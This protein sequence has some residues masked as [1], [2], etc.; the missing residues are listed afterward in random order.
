MN[1]KIEKSFQ[2]SQ[3]YRNYNNINCIILKFE[4]IKNEYKLSKNKYNDKLNSFI[5]KKTNKLI[6]TKI[7]TNK[8]KLDSLKKI[9][10][11]KI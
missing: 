3:F 9:L 8:T 10:D 5:N 1:Y 11:E 2:N 4:K 7:D 6:N